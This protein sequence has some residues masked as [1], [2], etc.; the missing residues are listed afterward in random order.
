[1]QRPRAAKLPHVREV[2]A[3]SHF[4]IWENDRPEF[5]SEA[6]DS[7]MRVTSTVFF[8]QGSRKQGLDSYF[9]KTWMGSS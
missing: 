9:L 8:V 1:M 3:A 5:D 7:E 6:L 4:L 2:P